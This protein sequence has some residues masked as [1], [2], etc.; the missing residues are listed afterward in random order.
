MILEKLLE[1]Q[2]RIKAIGRQK[3]DELPKRKN[4]P[5]SRYD[6]IEPLHKHLYKLKSSAY[7][8]I[9]YTFPVRQENV[10]QPNVQVQRNV[11]SVLIRLTLQ[12]RHQVFKNYLWL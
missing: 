1:E 11:R 4:R 8:R 3:R 6:K 7:R 5:Q 12:K 2:W 9:I 10:K